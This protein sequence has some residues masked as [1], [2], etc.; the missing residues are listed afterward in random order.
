[1]KLHGAD[2]QF[3]FSRRSCKVEI[4]FTPRDAD[5]RSVL[6]FRLGQRRSRRVGR[7]FASGRD[8]FPLPNPLKI[9]EYAS[10]RFFP[11]ALKFADRRRTTR[12]FSEY[13]ANASGYVTRR[14]LN[15]ECRLITCEKDSRR[16][17]KPLNEELRDLAIYLSSSIEHSALLYEC[18]SVDCRSDA[19]I[20]PRQKFN[21]KFQLPV[22]LLGLNGQYVGRIP[23]KQTSP[24][25]SRRV[26][27]RA[28]RR[29]A[30]VTGD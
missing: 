17:S 28:I 24:S 25:P 26:K 10:R 20:D 6:L 7:R 22:N 12:L 16:F 21:Y 14:G 3:F 27:R 2:V 11:L 23:V 8:F 15:L 19:P 29:G 30:V 1:M 13:A 4:P 9:G 5:D 18:Y